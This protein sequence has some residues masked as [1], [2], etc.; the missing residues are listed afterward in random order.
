M[1][2]CG[3]TVHQ[4][5]PVNTTIPPQ[6]AWNTTPAGSSADSFTNDDRRGFASQINRNVPREAM[7]T[8]LV[9]V[10]LPNSIAR[11]N[12]DRSDRLTGTNEPGT[13]SGQVGQPRP[14][15][16][17]R[18]VAPVT[19]ISPLVITAAQANAR[20][21]RNDGAR[22]HQAGLLAVLVPGEEVVIAIGTTV[23]WRP[24]RRRSRPTAP[25]W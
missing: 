9:R 22:R 25:R 17:T 10:R 11:W 2:R 14:E 5:S 24:S 18:T 23:R 6:I 1:S 7:S 20:C 19:A 13:H 3:A 16:V 21:S 8:T 4:D 15:P 12:A